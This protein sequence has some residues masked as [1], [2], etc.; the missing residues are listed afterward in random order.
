MNKETQYTINKSL[1]LNWLYSADKDLSLEELGRWIEAK[2]DGTYKLVRNND[3][4]L[5][6]P[7]DK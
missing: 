4:N 5:T 2:T 3:T 7:L 6:S 1:L